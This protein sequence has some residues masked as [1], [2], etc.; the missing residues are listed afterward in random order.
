MNKSILLY[1]TFL[2]IT[3]SSFAQYYGS[4]VG[5]DRRIGASMRGDHSKVKPKK[6]DYAEESSNY[7]KKE[8][9]LDDL[10]TAIFK[11]VFSEYLE[12]TNTIAESSDHNDV[13]REKMNLESDKLNLKFLEILNPEQVKKYDA[14]KNKKDKKGKKSKKSS[15]DKEDENQELL[16]E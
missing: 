13:K 16:Q 12:K 9:G 2:L 11:N 1:L 14:L 4:P 6:I 3:C 7:F 8:L 15:S 10:Q 5:L